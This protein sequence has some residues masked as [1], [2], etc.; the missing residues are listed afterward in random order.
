MKRQDGDSFDIEHAI[1]ESYAR[2]LEPLETPLSKNI[3]TALG[4]ITLII[5]GVVL[6]RIFYLNIERGDFYKARSAMNVEDPITIP[7]AR[8]MIYDRYGKVLADNKASHR[9]V[10]N[11]GLVKRENLDIQKIVDPLSNVLWMDSAE[12]M[13]LIKKADLEKSA[14]VTLA[15]NII[16]MQVKW[17]GE[18]SLRGVEIHEDYQREYEMGPAFSHLLGY[19]GLA[20]FNDVKGKVGLEEYYES[21]VG[22]KDGVRLVYR[23]AKNNILDEKFLYAPQNGKDIY[24]TIDAELQQYFYNR[25]Q[26]ALRNLGR[27]VGVGIAINPQTGEILS[28]ISLP[29]YDNNIFT[30]ISLRKLRGG[31]LSAPFEPL[32]NRVISG[33]YTPGSTIKPMVAVAALKEGIV[34]PETKVFSSGVLEIPN[35]YYP[36]QPSRFLDWK[37][38]GWVDVRSALAR[39]SNIYFYAVGGGI[40]NEVQGIGEVRNG[41]G[42]EKLKEYWKLFGFGEKTG[43]DMSGESAG[44]LPDP[45][46]KESRKKDIWRL[47]DTY[48]A[49]IGQ[50]DF[51]TTPIQLINYTAAIA[52]GGKIYKPYLVKSIN[53]TRAP[54]QGAVRGTASDK[55]I[56]EF[57]PEITQDLS[58]L[59]GEIKVAQEGMEDAVSKWYGTA[60]SLSS[61]AFDSAAKTGSSQ[62]S[63]NTKTNA[64][65]IGYLP[66]ETLAKAGAPVEKQIAI[67]VLIENAREGSLNAVPV[68]KDVLDWYYWNRVAVGN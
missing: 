34:T 27:N 28:L 47:G 61:L 8:G 10:L 35:P 53:E 58:Y 4:I 12:L 49:V 6:S 56:K 63:N 37:A 15:R 48:N 30:D 42:I 25:L 33:V 55:A 29:S 21:F 46:E 57:Q 60:Y 68:G 23:D 41:L 24:T 19:T 44:F 62:V 26:S 2:H 18:L 11:Y 13:D 39:S 14:L 59:S 7:A 43:I 40:P 54:E 45:Q 17:V 1:I 67:L 66:E 64:F 38:H 36:D 22:G 31:L 20:E 65:F 9:V 3:F 51:M 16:P 52:N 32:F 5:S 50:G